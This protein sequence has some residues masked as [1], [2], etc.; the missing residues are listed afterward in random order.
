MC[1]RMNG[2]AAHYAAPK[3]VAW[4]V[5]AVGISLG[6]ASG[7]AGRAATE[8]TV[9]PAAQWERRTPEA[10]G[11]NPAVLEA[12]GEL[13]EKAK[14]NGALVR[15]G[16]LA[17]DWSFG[18]PID[19]RF[20]TQSVAKSITSMLL[21]LALKE[22]RIARIDDRVKTYYP[23]FEVGPHT[24]EITFRHLITA[25]SGIAAKRWG[26]NYVDPQ[27]MAPGLECRYH[28]DHTAELAIA[29]TYIFGED[30][31]EVLRGRV[32]NKVGADTEWRPNG[33][34]RLAD[35]REVR[36]VMGCAFTHW[37]A[38]DL[39]RLGWLHL[40]QGRWEREQLLSTAYISESM[41]P[42]AVPVLEWRRQAPENR[43]MS[44]HTYGYAWRGRYTADGRLYWYMSGHGGQFCVLLPEHGIVMT[45]MNRIGADYQPFVGMEQ[46]EEH[47]FRLVGER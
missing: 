19:Q 9:F 16:Y 17:A 39:A 18:G 34:V 2:A 7:A 36:V 32:L 38:H 6:L 27:D 42:V 37:T 13:M 35:G 28:N 46:F 24:D 15:Q 41:T 22:G 44:K 25:T 3:A 4:I 12:L 30:L 10:L 40:N 20:E 23:E 45:K 5:L 31:E 33:S 14:A 26:E 47:L 8:E 43:D 11:L 29:L 21:G 1:N